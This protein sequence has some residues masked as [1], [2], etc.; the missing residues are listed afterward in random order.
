[1][2]AHWV[3]AVPNLYL[4]KTDHVL[5]GRE[6]PIGNLLHSKLDHVLLS[7]G[8]SPVHLEGGTNGRVGLGRSAPVPGQSNVSEVKLTM[9]P[10]RTNLLHSCPAE[11]DAGS[12]PNA[13]GVSPPLL[14]VLL[15]PIW[16]Y[17]YEKKKQTNRVSVYRTDI[18]HTW[19]TTR[20]ET[21]RHCCQ[22]DA[23]CTSDESHI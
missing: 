4:G 2:H 8:I 9:I 23:P 21:W 19:V 1:M 10:H 20:H 22:I 13:E 3:I 12:T 18:V 5:L 15:K 16:E 11:F 7:N 6:S 14:C 17:L